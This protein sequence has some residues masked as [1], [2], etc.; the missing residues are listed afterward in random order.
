MKGWRGPLGALTVLPSG[1]LLVV[2]EGRI[3]LGAKGKITIHDAG[4]WRSLAAVAGAGLGAIFTAG[5]GG[6]VMRYDG[7]AWTRMKTGVTAWLRGMYLEGKGRLW[8]WSGSARYARTPIVLLRYDGKAWSRADTGLQSAIKGVARAGSHIWVAGE[9]FLARREGSEWVS[10]LDTAK[11]GNDFYG[12]I[13]LC[14]TSRFLYAADSGRHSLVRP[15][16]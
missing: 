4:T 2:G 10:R 6:T 15:H 9:S 7:K 5:Q 8:G 16:R 13:G 12:L 1:E 14:A 3:G 11:L